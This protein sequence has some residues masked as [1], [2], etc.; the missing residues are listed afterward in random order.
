MS[1]PEEAPPIEWADLDDFWSGCHMTTIMTDP[2]RHELKLPSGQTLRLKTG[3]F[4]EV[5]RF[6]MVFVDAVGSFPPMPQKKAGAFL[7]DK[8]RGWLADRTILNVSDEAG[9]RGTLMG[10]IRRA[11]ASCPETDDPKDMERGAL[12]SHSDGAIWVVPRILLERVRRACP[13][14]FT[15]ADFYVALK[16]LGAENLEAQR[17]PGWRGRVWSI[18]A[19]LRPEPAMLPE[20]TNTNGKAP[21]APETPDSEPEIAR[22]EAGQEMLAGWLATQGLR[23]K[24]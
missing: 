4:F 14:K 1:D 24:E 7:L 8:F 19:T 9:D 12:Y 11:I 6:T 17:A 3:D 23:P 22:V 21:H 18:P 15:P 16:S 10:D 2:P 5:R 13:I 20:K